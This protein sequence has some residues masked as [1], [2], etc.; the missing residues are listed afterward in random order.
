MSRLRGGQI[1]F[2]PAA[3]AWLPPSPRCKQTRSVGA[4]TQ[5]GAWVEELVHRRDILQLEN[6]RLYL[7]GENETG[8]DTPSHGSFM[9]SRG[10]IELP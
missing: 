5:P 2:R 3:R 10:R 9:F 1:E 8:T 4:Q 7:V 6:G